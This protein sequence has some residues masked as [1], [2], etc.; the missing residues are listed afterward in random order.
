[1]LLKKLDLRQP[2]TLTIERQEINEVN[3]MT[4][5][6]YCLERESRLWGGVGGPNG[7]QSTL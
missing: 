6:I 3:F 1:M 4:A 2:N 7:G 5:P